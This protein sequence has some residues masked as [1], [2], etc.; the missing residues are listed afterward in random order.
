MKGEKQ[1]VTRFAPSPTGYL[2]IGGYRT[3]IFAYLY[4]KHNGGKF[5]LRIEDTDKERNKKEYEDNILE[6]L[7]WIGLE[8]DKFYRQ[9]ENIERHKEV[10]RELIKKGN[11]YISKEEAKDGSG[12][13]KEIV[14]FKNP[15]KVVKIHDLIKGTVVIDTTDLGDFVIARNVDDPL[16]HL[17]VVIDDWDEGVT[18]VI[19]GDEHLSNTPRQIL[20]LE[21]L[22]APIPAY[23]HI[24][25][26][27]GE[28][29]SKL[30]KRKG[31][32]PLTAYRDLGYLPEAMLNAAVLIGWNPGGE[33]EIFSKQELIKTF[34]LA[35]V[36]KSGAVFNPIKLD[37]INKEHLKHLSQEVVES[38]VAKR[39][40]NPQLIP[41]VL[42]RI[43]KWSDIDELI[44]SGE[45]DWAS[46]QPNY[47]KEGLFWKKLK[48]STNRFITTKEYIEKAIELLNSIPESDFNHNAVKQALWNYAE[49]KGRGEVLWPI[50]FAL[51]GLEKS[52]DPFTLSSILGKKET[53]KRLD[54]AIKK[55]SK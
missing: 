40:S 18:H 46:K 12:A 52:P 43:N 22:G 24:P 29:R 39:I 47:D 48:D 13:I 30:S 26:I 11:A 41:I 16:Y 9:S 42:D 31:A 10:I 21:A 44:K 45:L 33:Q 15:N 34:D 23:A 32:L 38:E 51:S 2:H 6:S 20:M 36:H 54:I 49:E 7:K 17:A 35:K 25:L 50:R 4:A 8:Y 55:L 27:L 3:A 5:I 1:V 53:M 19:R 28:D 14:R 37:W